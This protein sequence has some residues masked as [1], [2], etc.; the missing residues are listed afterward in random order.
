[1]GNNSTTD[2]TSPAL[3]LNGIKLP[4]YW[5]PVISYTT[6]SVIY[7][8]TTSSTGVSPVTTIPAS[9]TTT[10]PVVATTTTTTVSL[11]TT[12]TSPMVPR[13]PDVPPGHPYYDAIDALAEDGVFTGRED[14][15]FGPDG[16]V[17]RQ[18]FAKMIVKALGFTVT[19][20]EVCPFADV[21]AQVGDD[22]LYPSKYVAVC[23]AAGITTG[24]TPTTF[25]PTG[26]ITHQQLI[27]MIARAADLADPPAGYEPPFSAPQF[28]LDEHYQNARKAAYGGLLYGLQGIGSSYNF[29]APS[30]R[31]ECAQILYNLSQMQL[32]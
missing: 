19:G 6:T 8:D 16:A 13:F 2:R 21:A 28:S 18:Q 4:T 9:T 1:V 15:T 27:T 24:T 31:G 23:A 14:G 3:I 22:P 30:T 32:Q 25:N 11:T 10:L 26:K 7:Y 12:T 17:T 29:A 5:H 20:D